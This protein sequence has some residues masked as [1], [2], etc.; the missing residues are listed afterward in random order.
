[1]RIDEQMLEAFYDQQ[2]KIAFT[3]G[4]F[5]EMGKLSSREL[6]TREKA[7]TTVDKIRPYA[8][9]AAMGALPGAV[10]GGALTK[11]KIGPRIGLGLGA[12]IGV[13]DKALEDLS[14]KNR[15]YRKLL[16]SYQD[17]LGPKVAGAGFGRKFIGGRVLRGTTPKAAQKLLDRSSR[18][19]MLGETIKAKV[20]R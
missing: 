9:R 16:S 19:G 5:T 14:A 11:S 7:L 18:V 17:D 2:E 3:Q 15:K 10:I 8:Y 12:G 1:M 6:S 13:A 4:F 20:G